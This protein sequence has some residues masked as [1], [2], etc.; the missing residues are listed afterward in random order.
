MSNYSWFKHPKDLS[1]DKRVSA[2]IAREGGRGYGTYLYI[3]ETLYVQPDGKLHIEQ[4]R[5]MEKKGF[6]RKYMEK[7]VRNFNLFRI[8]ENEFWSVIKFDSQPKD[9]KKTQNELPINSQE[10]SNELSNNSQ[11]TCNELSNNYKTPAKCEEVEN[12]DNQHVISNIAPKPALARVREEKIREEKSRTEQNKAEPNDDD[13]TT[14]TDS[15]RRLIDNLLPESE[16]KEMACMKS[17]F[18][19]LLMKHFKEALEIFKGHVILHGKEQNICTREDARSYFANY[20]RQGQYTSIDLHKALLAIDT[21]QQVTNPYRYEQFVNGRRTY[22]GCPIP[23]GAPPR[24][25]ASAF[26]DENTQSWSLQ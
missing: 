5:T 6:G 14:K 1:N 12:N 7:V 20:S 26:W 3:I 13:G 19:Q 16:W 8:K 4:L 21:S 18:G 2:L 10:S 11:T 9:S 24:P 22:L 15:W 25:N 17:G 23:D